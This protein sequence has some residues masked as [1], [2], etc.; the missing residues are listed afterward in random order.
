MT[1]MVNRRSFL[2][3]SLATTGVA[4]GVA[5]AGSVQPRRATA[6]CAASRGDQRRTRRRGHRAAAQ[7]RCARRPPAPTAGTRTGIT[8][9]EWNPT[10]I[11]AQAGTLKVDTKADVAKIAPLD[12]KGQ[13]E[14]LVRRPE[15]GLAADR[16]RQR[17]SCGMPGS[18]TYPNI[19]LTMGDN[20][21]NLDYNQMLDKLRTAAAGN[22]APDVARLPILWGAEFAAKGQ[23]AEVQLEEFGFKRED[24]WSGALK[25]VTWNGKIY[26]VPTNNETMAFIWN[27][28]IFKDAG[29]D[30]RQSAGDLG[31]R[32]QVLGPDQEGHRQVRLRHG[33]P[34]Q[35]RQHAVPGHADAVGLRQR[36]ARRGR[37]RARPT[38]RC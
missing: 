33:R 7:R 20:V 37:A 13:A 15:P 31:R 9:A 19:P 18:A 23:L 25:S 26:G 36:R 27:K 3:W 1:R 6:G 24:F 5:A 32:G 10:T 21:Q 17:Q 2:K 12:Y 4:G 28:E 35:R 22:A 38:R 30:P 14:L 11:R 29:L 34:G 8:A 16:S